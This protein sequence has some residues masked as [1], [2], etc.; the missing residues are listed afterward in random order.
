MSAIFQQ[1]QHMQQVITGQEA[2]IEALQHVQQGP[3]VHYDQ[4]GPRA[5]NEPHLPK[6]S[7]YDGSRFGISAR[8]NPSEWLVELE[9]YMHTSGVAVE[10]M[11]AHGSTY[12]KGVALTMWLQE[13]ESRRTWG[14][15]KEWFL[16]AFQPI[17]ASKTARTALRTLKQ[18]YKQPVQEYCARF[19]RIINDIND[20]SLTDQ[21]EMFMI[22]LREDEVRRNVDREVDRVLPGSTIS[23]AQVMDLATREEA[24][25]DN[26]SRRFMTN[27]GKTVSF[28]PRGGWSSHAHAQPTEMDLTAMHVEVENEYGMEEEEQEEKYER[29]VT[30][31]SALNAFQSSRAPSSRPYAGSASRPGAGADRVPGLT[32]EEFTRLREAGKCFRCKKQGHVARECPLLSGKGQAQ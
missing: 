32:R 13:K 10:R 17:A 27:S 8:V 6:P 21:I 3:V 22:G 31:G 7:T 24:R 4:P 15:F 16:G 12:L 1:M 2:R 11:V 18:G 20:M 25:R 23:L 26:Q 9:H 19:V 14:E 5:S 30:V 29:E 28:P